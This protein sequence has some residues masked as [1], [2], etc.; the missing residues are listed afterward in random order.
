MRN[1]YDDLRL[2]AEETDGVAVQDTNDL[3]AGFRRIADDLAAYYVLGYYTTNTRFDGGI[4]QLRVRSKGSGAPIRAR[5]QYRAPTEAEIAALSTSGSRVSGGN[6]G[7]TKGAGP[8]PVEAALTALDRNLGTSRIERTEASLAGAAVIF[9]V[10]ARNPPEPTAELL[11]DRT[12]R[13]RVEWPSAGS[14][15]RREARLLD[16]T[17]KP[18]PVDLPLAEDSI[19]QVIVME[20]PL[21]PFSRGDY[22]IEL[23][24]AGGDSGRRLLAFRI[25]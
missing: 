3:N 21:A 20:L 4:R 11:F 13:I 24:G 1:A 12:E 7:G 22:L 10:R 2:L 17:G 15:D 25:R 18:M 23:T 9:R 5:R 14:T 6:S 16:R 8:S 19:K